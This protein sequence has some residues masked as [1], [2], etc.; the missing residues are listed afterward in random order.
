MFHS[1]IQHIKGA[2]ERTLTDDIQVYYE[3]HGNSAIPAVRLHEQLTL[4]IFPPG[5]PKARDYSQ[6]SFAFLRPASTADAAVLKGAG[7]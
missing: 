1:E 2:Y 3:G 7:F 5:T 4:G 6:K